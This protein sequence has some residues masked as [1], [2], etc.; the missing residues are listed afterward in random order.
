MYHKTNADYFEYLWHRLKEFQTGLATGGGKVSR[1]PSAAAQKYKDDTIATFVK[2]GWGPEA[3]RE[4][5]AGLEN[6]YKSERH[7]LIDAHP[8]HAFEGLALA[9]MNDAESFAAAGIRPEV[10]RAL[11][12]MLR[13]LRGTS[14]TAEQLNAIAAEYMAGQYNPVGLA[15]LPV[16]A[17]AP[18]LDTW[19]THAH[20]QVYN[21]TTAPC[22]H[23]SAQ[24]IRTLLTDKF[25]DHHNTHI[26]YYHTTN[27]KSA[28][29][30]IDG[31]SHV[32][33]RWC[34]DFK[35]TPCFYLTDRLSTA[36]RWGHRNNLKWFSE[37]CICVFFI[38]RTLP[39]QLS[40]K[41][42]EGAE[43]ESVVSSSRLCE[44]HDI[45]RYIDFIHGHIAVNV[46]DIKA[47]KRPI[48]HNPPQT[49]LACTS[50]AGDKFLD[51]CFAACIF[52]IPP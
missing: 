41:Y 51:K 32:H 33:G 11:Q 29:S 52:F 25:G 13:P 34:L 35:K 46:D 45:T 6:I 39:R 47:G 15:A 48:A 8:T 16:P 31:V 18:T 14:Y 28:K 3:I 38:P 17:A 20:I 21:I 37:T 50:D 4:R 1:V 2:N 42:I 5:L 40:Y 23:R 24:Q 12:R 26:P 10:A 9:F 44:H 36:L 43:W 30:I 22:T 7:M 27:W 19:T 49:Q